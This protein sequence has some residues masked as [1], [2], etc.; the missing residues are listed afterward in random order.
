[1]AMISSGSLGLDSQLTVKTSMMTRNYGLHALKLVK[2]GLRA[3]FQV[4]A[5][6][7]ELSASLER[8]QWEF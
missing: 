8:A 3:Q 5:L 6:Q 4:L 7:S 2:N 1:M